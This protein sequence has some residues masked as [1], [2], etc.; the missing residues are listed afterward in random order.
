M[1]GDIG[2]AAEIRRTDPPAF[3]Y[4]EAFSRNLGWVTAAEQQALRGKRVAIAGMGGVGGSHLLTLARL[5]I[6]AFNIADFDRFEL[7]NFNR[8]AGARL[9]SIGQPKAATLAAMARDVNPEL[10]LKVFPQ[11][12]DEGNLDDFL[13]GVD[14]YVDSLDFFVLD[15]RLKLFA[16][17]EALGIP[18]VIAAPIG[19]GTG[20]LVFMPG[21]MTFDQYFRLSGLPPEKQWVNF[22]LGLTPRGLQRSYLMDSSRV[23]LNAKR[24]PSTGLSC[25]L[26]AGVAAAEVLKIVL[27]RGSVRAAPWFHH[28][29]A[30]RCKWTRGWM[31]GGNANPLQ[32]AKLAIAYRFSQSLSR[33]SQP[34]TP[35]LADDL[36]F[37]LD[38]ARWAPSGDN[39]QPWRFEKIG[40]DRIVVHLRSAG[41]VYDYADGEPTLLAAGFL[42]ETL[43]LAASGRGRDMRWAVLDGTDGGHRISVEFPHRAAVAADPLLAYV[44]IRSVD[45]RAYRLT[46]LS[47]AQRDALKTALGEDLAIE[48]HDSLAER[49]RAA[50]TNALATD[51]RLRIREAYD[52][53]RRILDFDRDFSP[54]GIPARAIGLDPLTRRL[55]RWLMRDWRRLDLMNRFAFGTAIA[56]LEMDLIPGLCC[57]A[58]FTVRRKTPLDD[59]TRAETLLKAGASL[60]RFWLTATRLGLAMQP[61]LAPICFARPEPQAATPAPDGRRAKTAARLTRRLVSGDARPLLFMGRIGTQDPR[62]LATRSLRRDAQTLVIERSRLDD[63]VASPS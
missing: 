20:Y 37:I 30:Y 56:R 3:S 24:G 1:D 42:L 28:F 4:D 26:C 34:P 62:P 38:K 60:Q 63:E 50:R 53:H 51:I 5:G 27:K 46:P 17:L 12:I 31:P 49:W 57:A 54:T 55:M 21:K 19:M 8:Q 45:R 23:D 13:A 11:G 41:D 48:W 40:D 15:M 22:A 2:I 32:R 9:S 36:D 25:E 14:V 39:T 61:S 6:G 47:R 52:V 59:A 33:N 16:R 7:A 58:H 43:R 35:V 10:D 44:P 29:D 18:A